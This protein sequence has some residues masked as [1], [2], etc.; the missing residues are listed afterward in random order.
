MRFFPSPNPFLSLFFGNVGITLL[1]R[2]LLQL[3]SKICISD[4]HPLLFVTLP[5]LF[6]YH[7]LR[8]PL[9]FSYFV[10]IGNLDMRN[11]AFNCC[12]RSLL[13]SGTFF[14]RSNSR[15]PRIHPFILPPSPLCQFVPEVPQPAFSPFLAEL[16]SNGPLGFWGGP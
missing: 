14:R 16:P 10:L 3:Y 2:P 8:P 1:T 13:L 12:Q 11:Y 6:M 9:F 15:F 7:L 5:F 4:T